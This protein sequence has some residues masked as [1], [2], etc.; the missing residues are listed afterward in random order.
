M[1]IEKKGER[2]MKAIEAAQ[3]IIEVRFPNCDVALLGGSVARGEETITSDLD[4]VV[5][6]RKF[7]R[8][9]IENHSFATVGQLRC[10][11]IILKPINNILKVIVRGEDQ[12]F[13]NLF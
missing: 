10:L 6:D 8:L 1:Y 9:V 11:Y 3:N 13:L 4:I 5:L 12:R 7:C 2:E